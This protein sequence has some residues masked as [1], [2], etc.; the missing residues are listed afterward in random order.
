MARVWRSS[1]I[2]K[3]IL[4]DP[5][6][7]GWK[8]SEDIE[9]CYEPIMTELLQVQIW[10]WYKTLYLQKKTQS[11]LQW[12]MFLPGLWESAIIFRRTFIKRQWKWRQRKWHKR[13]WRLGLLKKLYYL[14]LYWH[15]LCWHIVF[16]FRLLDLFDGLLCYFWTLISR[17]ELL[18][19]LQ[20]TMF[21]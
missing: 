21:Y 5:C 3:P 10:M 7:F 9:N 18:R 15:L 16:T 14:V 19:Y 6:K 11:Y 4:P 2:S 13:Y 8:L 20:E 1:H 12:S 17:P